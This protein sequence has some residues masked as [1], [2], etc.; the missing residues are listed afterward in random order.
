M[1]AQLITGKHEWAK[2]LEKGG[3][4]FEK[5]M[6]SLKNLVG[7]DELCIGLATALKQFLKEVFQLEFY[8]EPFYGKLRHLLVNALLDE[9]Q[10][11]S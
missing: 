2:E 1:L 5:K 8:K 11:P 3:S 6:G 10:V 4:C 9:D 7:P